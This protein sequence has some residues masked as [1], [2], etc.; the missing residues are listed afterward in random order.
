MRCSLTSSLCVGHA[1]VMGSFY[2][3]Y[4]LAATISM[5]LKRENA[6]LL[7]VVATLFAAVF[8]GYVTNLPE[9]LKKARVH[10]D[11]LRRCV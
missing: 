1:Q 7:A 10:R 2:A 4:G 5:V 3:V 6:P 8:G 11:D 9:F